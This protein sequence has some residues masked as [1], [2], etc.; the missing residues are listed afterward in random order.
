[1]G[2]LIDRTD[3]GYAT[4]AAAVI[5]LTI[6]LVV[7]AG[8][9]RAFSE[10]RL[11]QSDFGRMQAE[12]A[13]SGAQSAA[14]L[15]IATSSRP[16]PYR[17]TLPSLGYGVDVVAEPE[18]AKLTPT[19]FANVSDTWLAKF[20][21][22][23]PEALK[24]RIAGLAGATELLWVADEDAARPWSV[25]GPSLVSQFGD[26]DQPPSGAYEQPQAGE[27]T[28]FWRAGEVWRIQATEPSGWRDERIVRFTGNGL[29]PA[30]IIGRR[31]TKGW[32]GAQTCQALS[33]ASSGG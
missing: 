32:K 5:S 7:T 6:A 17:W 8:V 4:P 25:C 18:S 14:A 23:D 3:D 26:S 19:A 28:A 27:Q 21:V 12:Q 30:V 22:T 16:P 10:L 1:M 31:L 20:G 24:S 15:A 13:L 9:T 29:Q 33:D 2:C 11:S